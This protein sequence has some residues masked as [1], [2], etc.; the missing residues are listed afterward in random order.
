M[1]S[2]VRVT[3]PRGII[4]S[5]FVEENQFPLWSSSD[6]FKKKQKTITSVA[7]QLFPIKLHQFQADF[8]FER[9]HE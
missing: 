5:L 4:H 8:A 7:S 6:C 1:Q 3:K 9:T 2:S